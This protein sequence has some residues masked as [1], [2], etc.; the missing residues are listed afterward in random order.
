MDVSNV[1]ALTANA[2][3]VGSAAAAEA[4]RIDADFDTFLTLLTAQLNNQDPLKPIDN[5]EFVAQLAQFSSVEQQVRT[6]DSLSSILNALGGGGAGL[7]AWLGQEVEVAAPLRFD[8]EP[9]QLTAPRNFEAN[10]ATLIVEDADARI[11]A[12]VAVDP[13]EETFQW[14]G[15]TA[16]GASAEPGFYS[17]TL[18]R[19][20]G[21]EVLDTIAP[22]GF[23]K[24][25][26]ARIEGA[27]QILVTEGGGRVDA[28]SVSAIRSS[29]TEA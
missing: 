2:P 23:T 8:G 12:R 18:E 17:F 27:S 26:E 14:T 10:A 7:A 6:N 11:V 25:T 24:V 4:A 28:S 13:S 22:A 19:R 29:E 5:T 16:S 1:D 9:V 3:T 21:D 15:E 20:N